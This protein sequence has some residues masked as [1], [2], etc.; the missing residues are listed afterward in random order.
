[1]LV[2]IKSSEAKLYTQVAL[3]SESDGC[4]QFITP[5]AV[6]QFG[7]RQAIPDLEVRWPHYGSTKPGLMSP[8][9]GLA[10]ILLF[11]EI[12]ADIQLGRHLLLSSASFWVISLAM[13]LLYKK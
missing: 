3:S 8:A 13:K 2:K 9:G 6:F 7:L 12:V 1:M 5:V 10:V 4:C 11:E